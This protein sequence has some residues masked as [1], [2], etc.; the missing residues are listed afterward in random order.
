MNRAIFLDRDGT[1]IK[2]NGYINNPINVEFYDYTFE[3]LYEL[4]KYFQLFI[5]TNQPGIAKGIITHKEVEKVHSFILKRM[6]DEGIEIKE[7]Y[8]CPHQK[9]DKCLCRKPQTFFIDKA[10]N[11]YLINCESSYVIGDHP[12]DIKLSVNA[13]AKG[14]YIL[15][16]HGRKHYHELIGTTKHKIKICRNLKYAT[17]TILKQIKT[18]AHNTRP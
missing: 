9:I 11:D 6:K 16:G 8:C 7:I 18:T 2:D 17:K 4:H 1:I 12:E 13:N 14:I 5:I 3:C 10:K 15:T